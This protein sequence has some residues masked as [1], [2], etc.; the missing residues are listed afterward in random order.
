[1]WRALLQPVGRE[2]T[3]HGIAR[4]EI[5]QATFYFMKLLAAFD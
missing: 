4:R 5:R 1:L 2:I 3:L